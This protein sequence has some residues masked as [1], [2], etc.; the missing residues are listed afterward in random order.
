MTQFFLDFNI[1]ETPQ[2]SSNENV[3][4]AGRKSIRT[5][6]R[7]QIEFKMESVD[8]LL[9]AD[10]RA[11]DIWDYV[12]SL[13]LTPFYSK[14]KI[15][16]GCGGPRTVD[17]RV[18]LALWLYAMLEGV[19]SARHI[20]NLSKMHSAYIWICGGV[21]INH[22]TLSDF[23]TQDPENFRMLLQES[24]A[25]MWKTGKFKPDTA[26]QDGTR[27]KADAG[28]SSARR[29]PKL[30][31]YLVEAQEYLKTLE[32][33]HAANPSAST[34]REKAARR[35]AALE[36][37]ERL[38]QAQAEMKKY[39]QERIDSAKKNHHSLSQ[40]D[41]EK[42][43]VSVTDPECRKMK[44]GDG[45]FRLAYNVQFATSTD[46]QV[47]LGVDVVNTLDPGTLVPM[48]QQV[49]KNLSSTGC[50][51]PSKWLADSAYANKADAEAAEVNFNDVSLYS[52][53]VGNGKV[54]G[55]TPRKTD[56]EAMIN[57]RERMSTEESKVIYKERSQ[58]AEFANAAAKNRGMGKVLVRGLSKVTSM[59]LLYA[60]A[61]NMAVYFRVCI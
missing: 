22:H 49:K 25:I 14:I 35:R 18:L 11:R 27:I 45:G 13:E 50:A 38:E 46:K 52:P 39:K 47:I 20:A 59:A 21:S 10:H 48:M 30:E 34:L 36:R 41:L 58:T 32:E 3:F 53:P 8:D 19:A 28:S 23:R 60:V 61:H 7:Q 29:E 56:N 1:P 43:R 40:T 12:V 6:N 5:P 9:P 31:L 4:I 51:M 54:D 42:T 33:E 44:M 15:G 57:L 2:S 55:L 17:P 16:E 26:A 37:K 24:I